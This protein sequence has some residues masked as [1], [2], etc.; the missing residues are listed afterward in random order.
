[1]LS[2]RIITS[3]EKQFAQAGLIAKGT[4][5]CLMGLL[6]LMAAFNIVGRYAS[7]TDK[8]GVF[9]FVLKQTGGQIIMGLIAFGLICYSI[10]RGIQSVGDSKNKGNDAKGIFLRARYLFSG[11]VYGSLALGAIEAL[12]SNRSDSDDKKQEM[13]SELLTKPFGEWLVGI[14]AA[15]LLGVGIF[16]I[17]YGFSEQYKK[18]VERV[19]QSDNTKLL[20]TAGKLGYVARGIVW[21]LLAWLFLKAALHANSSKAGDTSKA[22]DFLQEAAYGSYLLG[23]VGFGLICYGVFNFVRMRYEKFN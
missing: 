3:Y 19:G 7:N 9:E 16:Q 8:D 18:L 20:M 4:V 22:F 11:L 17:W 10:W 14:A 6:A 5:Y 21:L 13:V 15:I 23:S 12:V 2:A 1:M